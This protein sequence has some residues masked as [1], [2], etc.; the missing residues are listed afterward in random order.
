[1][2]AHQAFAC[3]KHS[4]AVRQPFTQRRIRVDRS[5]VG[6]AFSVSVSSI[7]AFTGDVVYVFALSNEQRLA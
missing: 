3:G 1:M 2:T 6:I 4:K 5:C 7:V